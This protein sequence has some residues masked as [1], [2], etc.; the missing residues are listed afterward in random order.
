MQPTALAK[1]DQPLST[2]SSTRREKLISWPEFQNKYLNREDCFKYEW[3]SGTVV[4]STNMDYTQLYIVKNLLSFFR[5]FYQSGLVN[6][7]LLPDSDFFF[8]RNLD[9]PIFLS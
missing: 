8:G 7:E 9:V 3:V 1:P 5:T 4:K 6:G 2:I